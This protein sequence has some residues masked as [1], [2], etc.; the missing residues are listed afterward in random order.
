M[1]RSALLF[2]EPDSVLAARRTST[3]LC[4]RT[5]FVFSGN[6]VAGGA[7]FAEN[8]SFV[9]AAAAAL[10]ACRRDACEEPAATTAPSVRRYL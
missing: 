9:S 4:R 2:D 1:E 6:S 8:A 7:Y 10:R 5:V 3:G